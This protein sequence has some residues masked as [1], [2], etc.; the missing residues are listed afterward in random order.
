MPNKSPAIY[1]DLI[2]SGTKFI[3]L[4]YI[5][6]ILEHGDSYIPENL[7][8]LIDSATGEIRKIYNWT[9]IQ[10][11]DEA[12]LNCLSD[13]NKSSLVILANHPPFIH[14]K[15]EEF[16]QKILNQGFTCLRLS[17][18]DIL[19][20]LETRT[21]RTDF[22]VT[23]PLYGTIVDV[24]TE[25]GSNETI[26]TLKPSNLAYQ[27]L[28]D[29]TTGTTIIDKLN[30]NQLLKLFLI[31]NTN[32]EVERTEEEFTAWFNETLN[33]DIQNKEEEEGHLLTFDQTYDNHPIFL[34]NH[35]GTTEIPHALKLYGFYSNSFDSNEQ[36]SFNI[37]TSTI[38]PENFKAVFRLKKAIKKH[39]K[40]ISKKFNQYELPINNLIDLPKNN[41]PKNNLPKNKSLAS[42]SASMD[43]TNINITNIN[44][45][46]EATFV[47]GL[48]LLS[49][50]CCPT[51]TGVDRGRSTL[52]SSRGSKAA[53]RL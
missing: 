1:M 21:L 22:N 40:C 48:L 43:S 29:G 18:F 5:S 14:E 10:S 26:K 38:T 32:T 45:S 33:Q 9:V 47:A 49:L 30:Y 20:M 50:C 34:F 23:N 53:H 3:E 12:I 17:H 4:T 41:L 15:S 31:L 7:R 27:T 19:E 13:L 37:K 25:E 42:I 6:V 39:N 46:I 16:E 8:G 24:Q 11:N 51:P 36:L 2:G 44:N 28:Y 52:D 35:T